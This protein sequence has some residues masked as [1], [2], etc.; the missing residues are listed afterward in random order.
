MNYFL[1][2]RL[3]NLI[4]FKIFAGNNPFRVCKALS[5]YYFGPKHEFTGIHLNRIPSSVRY[6]QFAVKGHADDVCL[7]ALNADISGNNYENTK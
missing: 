4:D 1:V 7:S 3:Y 5:A 6:V 2:F